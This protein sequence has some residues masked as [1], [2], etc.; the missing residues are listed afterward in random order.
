MY[1][2]HILTNISFTSGFRLCCQNV[3]CDKGQLTVGFS[4]LQFRVPPVGVCL[5]RRALIRLGRWRWINCLGWWCWAGERSAGHIVPSW[6]RNLTP[7]MTL[8][9]RPISQ[10]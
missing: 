6:T 4:S 3:F 5:W 9:L 7:I 10:W 1:L 2:C 8:H